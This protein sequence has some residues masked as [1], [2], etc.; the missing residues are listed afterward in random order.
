MDK[1]R[2]DFLL[3]ERF[4]TNLLRL[5]VLFKCLKSRR[6]KRSMN[7][8]RQ[9]MKTSHLQVVPGILIPDPNRIKN[10]SILKS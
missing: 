5:S 3:F 10:S 9:I 4:V 2:I 8:K 7:N 6:G 1:K